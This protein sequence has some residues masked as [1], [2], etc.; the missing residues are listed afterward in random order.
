[1]FLSVK[2][3]VSNENTLKMESFLLQL[4]TFIW[5][6]ENSAGIAN[7]FKCLC[8]FFVRDTF[9]SIFLDENWIGL[10]VGQSPTIEE[11]FVKN[12][13]EKSTLTFILR[14]GLIEIF[15]VHAI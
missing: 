13:S 2:F 4:N 15:F 3:F 5:I 6:V 8:L 10:G 7:L 11:K 12:W 9:S 14:I 1:M